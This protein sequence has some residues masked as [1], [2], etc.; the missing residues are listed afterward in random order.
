M[1]P[2]RQDGRLAERYSL[3]QG[4]VL[5][6]LGGVGRAGGQDHLF[7]EDALEF[8]RQR[9]EWLVDDSRVETSA[10]H[11]F[12]QRTPCYPTQPAS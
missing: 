3:A 1:T 4:E 10:R 9:T 11:P 5:R 12:D 8:Q 2:D 7:V 6:Q